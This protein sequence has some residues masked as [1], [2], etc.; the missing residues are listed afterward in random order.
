MSRINPAKK[1]RYQ[2]NKTLFVFGEGSNDEI[3]LKYLRS[4]YSYGRNIRVTIRKGKG[5]SAGNVII[6]ASKVL[7]DFDE[8]VVVL[9]NDKPELEMKKA[10]EEAKNRNIQLLENTPCLECL[11][12]S[13]LEE[14]LEE[15][16]SV[17]YKNR[18]E[19]GYINKRK[20]SELNEYSKLFPKELLNKK[21]KK[22]QNLNDLISL[23]EGGF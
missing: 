1:K 10:R 12:L 5:G 2:A 7:G 9:D 16:S 19:S 14:D 17:W 20:R 23:M 22:L 3:F 13:I 11:L 8:R 18:F 15:K 4:I 21:R 6:D